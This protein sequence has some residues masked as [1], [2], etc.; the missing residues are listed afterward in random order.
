MCGQNRLRSPTAEQL[1]A[2]YPGIEVRSAGLKNGAEERVTP[3]LVA[4]ADVIFV[5]ERSQRR[6]LQ[7]RFRAALDGQRVICLDIPDVYDYMDSDL[8]QRLEAT[9]PRHLGR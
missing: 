3:E 8:V 4:W 9:V 1:F 6:K 2:G 5:M 7:T